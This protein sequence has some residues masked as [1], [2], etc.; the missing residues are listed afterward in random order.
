M[1]RLL[2]PT[3]INPYKY[4]AQKAEKSEFPARRIPSQYW[5]VTPVDQKTPLVTDGHEMV[6]ELVF[7]WLPRCDR[8][9]STLVQQFH[10]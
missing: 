7:K 6:V 2:E 4:H 1:D 10:E 8:L 9:A 5:L 3:H